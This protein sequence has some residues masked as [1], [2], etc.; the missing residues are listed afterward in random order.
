M[1]I[2]RPVHIRD[3]DD[4]YELA[5][6]AG[7][8]LTTL[9]ADKKKLKIKIE[10]SVRNFESPPRGPDG[11]S[12]FLVLED[13]D[14]MK[15]VGTAAV[16]SKVGGFEP[17][18]TY[19]LK[20]LK[21]NSTVIDI[22]NKEIKYLE[23]KG[24]NDGPSEIGTLFLH[25][26][27]RTGTNG[28][29]LSFSRFMLAACF[30]HLFEDEILAELR[31]TIDGSGNSVFWDAIGSKFFEIPFEEADALVTKNKKFIDELMP[32]IPVYVNI[33][34][35]E[36]QDAIGK[37]HEDSLPALMLLKK[38]GFTEIPEYD[39]FE[40]GPIVSAKVKDIR[41]IKDSKVSSF[42]ITDKL[43]NASKN[44]LIAT[45]C[46]H[47][48]NFKVLVSDVLVNKTKVKLPQET[49]KQLYIGRSEKIR[50]VPIRQ[51]KT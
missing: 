32:K 12:Y 28:R 18:W 42:D 34:P 20:T 36:A 8:G 4:V 48:R 16:Y 2:V 27:Y 10:D 13:R 29:L 21:R 30:P 5:K 1:F 39:I 17:F 14:K 9:P 50:F 51:E 26:D 40:A 6:I 19:E 3:L 37:I 45:E 25:P 7:S 41:C 44:M 47:I 46:K 24:I 22:V 38:E 35:Q 23:L 49:F 31:G 11:S 15:V 43:K 33:L